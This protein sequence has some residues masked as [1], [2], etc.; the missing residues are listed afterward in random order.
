MCGD[1]ETTLTQTGAM[2]GE[3]EAEQSAQLYG[4]RSVDFNNDRVNKSL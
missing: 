1:D 2:P 3:D 4:T